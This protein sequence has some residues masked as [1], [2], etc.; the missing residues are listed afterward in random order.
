[1]SRFTDHF[2]IA[3]RL[4]APKHA[5]T[6]NGQR[7]LQ[8]ATHAEQRMASVHS[9][10]AKIHEMKTASL[11]EYVRLLPEPRPAYLLR[12]IAERLGVGEGDD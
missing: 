2:G 6:V 9:N 8:D 11:I 12:E 7:A 4:L 3:E 1:V 10:L 5:N